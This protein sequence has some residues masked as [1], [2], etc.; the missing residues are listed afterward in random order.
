MFEELGKWVYGCV[1]QINMKRGCVFQ[2][3]GYQR[4]FD[5]K[6]DADEENSLEVEEG[7]LWNNV[8]VLVSFCVGCNVDGVGDVMYRVR[9]LERWY[10]SLLLFC[11]QWV[12][13]TTGLP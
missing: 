3:R 7:M 1:K 4:D 12:K 8:H 5:E 10:L 11:W 13:R 6:A 9:I 2:F